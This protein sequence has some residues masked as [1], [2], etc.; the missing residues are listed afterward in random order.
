MSTQAAAG[1]SNGFFSNLL[2]GVTNTVSSLSTAAGQVL[3]IW[4]QAQH[5]AQGSNQLAQPTVNQSK[6]APNLNGIGGS[7]QQTV[8]SNPWG[9]ALLVG[10][11]IVAVIVIIKIA[12]G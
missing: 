6:L 8:Q 12:K 4:S 5:V 11:G 7:V 3:P 9:S 2:S 10:A 1:G